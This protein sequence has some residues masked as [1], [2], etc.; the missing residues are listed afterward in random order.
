MHANPN[1]L[2]T[3]AAGF[4]GGRLAEV[5]Y[6]QGNVQVRAGV[7][8]W[9]TAAR[10]A[11]FPVDIVLCD[12]MSP[13]QIA[14]AMEGVSTV[15]HCAYSDEYEVIVDG[16]RHMLEAA[17]QRGVDRFI[18]LSTAEVYGN[19]EGSI[20][21][22]TPVLAG[23]SAY[24][25][26]KIAAEELCWNYA[27]Q[28]VPITILRPSIIHGPFS[29]RTMKFAERLRSGNWGK[30]EAHGDGSCNLV[31]IDDLI[32]AILCVMEKDAAIGEVFNINGP[33]LIS[34]NEYFHA[35]N[36]ALGL[37]PLPTISAERSTLK[38]TARDQ[39]SGVTNFV[40]NRYGDRLM[41]LYLQGGI[42]STLMKQVKQRLFTIPT[43]SELHT[44]YSRQATYVDTKARNTLGYEPQFEVQEALNLCAHWLNHHYLWS[45]PGEHLPVTNELKD[46]A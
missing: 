32:N 35:F 30:F 14:Q 40:L 12:I 17:T 5:L 26:A 20:D 31:Y 39:I 11:R 34:W 28:N 37:S 38:S 44:L 4:V 25:N 18:Y 33:S 6:L 23:N 21:E 24:A 2:I 27:K 46:A 7:R 42:A 1:V 41:D 36:E 16:T 15:I 43:A 19:V 22:T 45:R 10:T 29:P 13:T 3:G 9:S 8:S